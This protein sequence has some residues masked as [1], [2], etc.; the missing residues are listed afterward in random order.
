MK[1]PDIGSPDGFGGVGNDKLVEDKPAI[2]P[3]LIKYIIPMNPYIRIT[4]NMN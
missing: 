4:A 1:N 2:A 3:L